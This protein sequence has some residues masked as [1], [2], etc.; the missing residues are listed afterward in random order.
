MIGEKRGGKPMIAKE[1]STLLV[2]NRGEIALRI[3]RTARA[4]GLRVVAVYSDADRDA[5]HVRFADQAQAIGPAPA[6]GS[7]LNIEAVIQAALKSGTDAVHPGY[8]FL[9]ENAD[10]ASA[11]AEA[12]LI[13]VGP[14]PHTITQMGDKA[15][16]RALMQESGVPVV[17]GYQ[18]ED[19]ARILADQ[20]AK[21]GYPVMIKAAAGGG[22]KGMRMV[23][24]PDTF[25]DSLDLA[26]AEA[27]NAFGSDH[28]ILEKALVNARHVEIQIMADTFGNVIHLGERDC[29]VQRRHQKV[30]EEAPSP[31]V[32][33]A[34]RAKMGAVAIE[35]ARAVDYV[36]AGTVEFLLDASG[37]FYFLEMNTRLQVEHPVTEMVTGL[38]LVSL[39]LAVARGDRLPV[40]QED[41]QIDGWAMEARLYAE[42]PAAGFLPSAGKVVDCQ[43]PPPTLGRCDVA[44]ERGMDVS[45]FY[46][47]MLGKITARGTNREAA[48]RALRA[49]LGQVAVFGLDTNRDLL[50][51]VLNAPVFANG[52]ADT[53]WLDGAGLHSLTASPPAPAHCALAAVLIHKASADIARSRAFPVA[54]ELMGWSSAGIQKSL[55]VLEIGG[56]SAPYI[57]ETHAQ[58]VF[59]VAASGNTHTVTQTAGRWH[60]DGAHVAVG[61]FFHAGTRSHLAL[62]DVSFDCEVV[63]GTA[64]QTS[65]VQ[66]GRV[67]SP[68][69]GTLIALDV[70]VGDTVTVGQPLAVLEAMKLQHQIVAPIDGVV[71]RVGATLGGQIASGVMIC[72]IEAPSGDGKG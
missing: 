17:P 20:A 16:A 6:A 57:I 49:A 27:R 44:L 4:E 55:S 48:R 70:V 11:C 54:S 22:G 53:T 72:E 30:I 63:T 66:Q 50:I 12:G 29:S 62:A 58:D 47:P 42:T 25:L 2:A 24:T 7:Y 61:A 64:R 40:T 46:D 13:F 37:D 45:T 67:T 56:K 15:E 5:P 39:Q 60:V 69:H 59:T 18:G 33:E 21:I 1:F 52:D 32:N 28:V 71:A 14:L 3:M 26:R 38:D 35:V 36:G 8:G 43:L 41:V 9:S 31:A 10:F 19:D 68:M 34:L 23:A 51:D 65:I